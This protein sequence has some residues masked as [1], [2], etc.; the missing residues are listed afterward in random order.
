MSIQI[1]Q[2]IPAYVSF[3]SYLSKEYSLFISHLMEN[4]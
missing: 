3:I 1:S 4:N 2:F